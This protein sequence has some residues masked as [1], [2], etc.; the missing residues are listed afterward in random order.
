MPG[1]QLVDPID[2]MLG[3]ALDDVA[4]ISLWIEVIELGRANQAVD[5]R[6]ALAT[7]I[8]TAEQV[9]FSAEG[10]TSAG[11]GSLANSTWQ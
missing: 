9:I 4:Q 1:Q 10:H 6:G 2:R 5:G 8:G 11:A 7:G 3:D